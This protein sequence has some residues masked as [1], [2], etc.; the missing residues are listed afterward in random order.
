M[1]GNG[2]VD[3]D[4]LRFLTSRRVSHPAHQER[5]V[6]SQ[7]LVLLSWTH[8][9]VSDAWIARKLAM[10]NPDSDNRPSADARADRGAAKLLEKFEEML[11]R[12]Q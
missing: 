7:R 8:T 6:Q 11:I 4:V 10:G 9:T 3:Q 1:A 2:G 5:Q 12:A